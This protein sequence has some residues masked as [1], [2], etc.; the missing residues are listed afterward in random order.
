M[1][2]SDEQ[3]ARGR[4]ADVPGRFGLAGRVALVTGGGRG[5]G[6]AIAVGFAAAGADLCVTSRTA[7]ELESVA[8][9]VRALGRRATTVT[10]DLMDHRERARIVPHVLE[11]MGALDI[12]VN[13]AGASAPKTSFVDVALDEWEQ[14][15][16]V[17]LTAQAA[18]SQDVVRA[19]RG[20]ASIVNIA[21]VY[22]LQGSP[23]GEK[24]YGSVTS[25]TAAKHGLVG[26]TRALAIE[27]APVGIR[28]NALCPGWVDT[29][30]NHALD[31]P[32]AFLER[33]LDR[34]PMGRWA[35]PDEMV[36]P[37]IFLASDASS[38]MTG[39]TLVVD[40]GLLA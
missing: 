2:S 19:V 4:A 22:G 36:G 3:L 31:V 23:G 7:D 27:L 6:R 30:M 11:R 24:T 20:S 17:L 26:L 5:I 15:L 25:Y 13:N 37:A 8:D 16:V 33:C 34:I 40:G 32:T 21:S 1:M 10:A 29:A 12:L 28:V 18:L 14:N 39:Q 38:Y 9:E 35:T